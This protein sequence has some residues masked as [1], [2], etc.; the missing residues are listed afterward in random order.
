[1]SVFIQIGTNNGD[2]NFR[3]LVLKHKPSRVILIE[4]NK[5]LYNV[6]LKN[7]EGIPNVI[8]LNNAI[9][10]EDNKNV[11]LYIAA[12]NQ[13]YGSVADNGIRYSDELFS[14]LPMNDWGDKSDMVKITAN[15]IRFDTLCSMLNI[16]E[17]DYLQ[18]DTEGFDSEIIDMIDFNT[19]T[20]H[21][22]RYENWI[23]N[24]EA[25]TKHNEDKAYKLG[26]AGMERTA[27]KLSAY[28]Y[29]LNNIND[30]DGNDIIASRKRVEEIKE[31]YKIT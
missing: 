26:K 21:Q 4:P 30:E 19:Y 18:I 1:M 17:I 20:I 10:Y 27:N 14:L 8:I 11:E 28:G 7:Y 15:S 22:L 31:F 25:F 16:S 5:A 6:I 9:Y 12:K 24:T 2:D 23:F 3:K 13:V 29:T